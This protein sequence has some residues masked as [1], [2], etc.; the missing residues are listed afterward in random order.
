MYIYIYIYIYVYIYKYI[1]IYIFIY[2]YIY[3][4]IFLPY[5]NLISQYTGK[6]SFYKSIQLRIIKT[7][8]TTKKRSPEIYKGYSS[9]PQKHI[10]AKYLK[11]LSM[12]LFFL[13]KDFIRSLIFYSKEVPREHWRL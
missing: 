1:Y 11:N 12:K 10:P 6:Q 4:Y 3:I 2:I 8:S 7:V 13:G 9:Y 5:I